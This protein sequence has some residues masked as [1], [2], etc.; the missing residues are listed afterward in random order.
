MT[1]LDPFKSIHGRQLFLDKDGRLVV[2]GAGIVVNNDS[3]SPRF[4]G[5]S[6]PLALTAATVTLTAADHSGKTL[7]LDRA[8]GIVATLPAATGSGNKYRFVV[9]TV[10]TSNAHIVKV[11][12]VTD[13]I[14]G[15]AV[16]VSD[17]SAAVL[18]YAAG[19]ADDTISLNGTTTGGLKI[20]DII[21]L[22]DT[23]AGMFVA[24]VRT[25]ASGTEATPFSATV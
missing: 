6:V 18:G 17:N 14:Q 11:A 16:V 10:P 9:K 20:G 19:A 4:L 24:Y 23:A 5:G 15:T 8:A 22:E 2:G 7:L 3:G 25:N 1:S 12:N 21:E 13:I